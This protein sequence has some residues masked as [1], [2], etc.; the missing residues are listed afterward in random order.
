[1]KLVISGFELPLS[2]MTGQTT[3]LEIANQQLFTRVAQSLCSGLGAQAL[4][5]YSVWDGDVQLNPK[6]WCLFISD[7]LN[8][9]WSHKDL[10]SSVVKKIEAEFLSDEDLRLKVERAQ[11][12]IMSVLMGLS[13][14]LESMYAFEAE[15][16]FKRCLKLLGFNVVAQATT[17]YLDSLINFLGLMLDSGNKRVLTFVNLKTFLTESDLK[18]FYEHVFYSKL[19]VLLLEN[20]LDDSVHEYEHKR[21]VDQ[22]FLEV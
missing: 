15:W 16:D 22:C 12:E 2:L 18:T 21:L 9:P 14:G 7:P 11:Q 20:K 17:S 13:F 10:M 3:V 8:L 1:M 6:E 19:T 5:A 4:E